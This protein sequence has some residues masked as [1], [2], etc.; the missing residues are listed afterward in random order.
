MNNF[1][2][3]VSVTTD[4]EVIDDGVTMPEYSRRYP[5]FFNIDSTALKPEITQRDIFLSNSSKYR[6]LAVIVSR[7]QQSLNSIYAFH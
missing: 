7:W 5:N 1:P 4:L 2:C 6:H 3:T